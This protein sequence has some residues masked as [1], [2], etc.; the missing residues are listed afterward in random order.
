MKAYSGQFCGIY[1]P[2]NWQVIPNITFSVPH[3][4]QGQ[5]SHPDDITV[6]DS[7]HEL[8]RS[9]FWLLSN[10]RWIRIC[11]ASAVCYLSFEQSNS[12]NF[13]CLQLHYQWMRLDV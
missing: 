1:R 13:V 2:T 10:P 11:V 12:W 4:F 8:M 9:C 5:A 3:T 6:F 7:S